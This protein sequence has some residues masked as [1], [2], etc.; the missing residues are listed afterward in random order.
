MAS[1]HDQQARVDESLNQQAT[2]SSDADQPS[3][4]HTNSSRPPL[5][6]SVASVSLP[7]SS[8]DL[9]VTTSSVRRTGA[10]IS[11]LRG[12][13]ALNSVDS[14]LLTD[15]VVGHPGL[16][17]ALNDFVDYWHDQLGAY[18]AHLE[19]TGQQLEATES[20]YQSTDETAADTLSGL[21][22]DADG[23]AITGGD[24]AW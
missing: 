19:D 16:A 4:P 10:A 12:L 11:D 13:V 1:R 18:A 24:S 17:R 23:S 22:P 7:P 20:N 6:D 15:K 9:D 14:T 2:E 3:P 8:D 21:G 5:R